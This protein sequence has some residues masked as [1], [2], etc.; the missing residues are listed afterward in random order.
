MK[1]YFYSHSTDKGYVLAPDLG[2][3]SLAGGWDWS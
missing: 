3:R 1:W 2:P